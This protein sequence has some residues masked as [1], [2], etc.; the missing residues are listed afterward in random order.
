MFSDNESILSFVAISIALLF[1]IMLYAHNKKLAGRKHLIKI[2]LKG[3]G[4]KNI[5]I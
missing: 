4:I 3:I 5:S 2:W 1:Q